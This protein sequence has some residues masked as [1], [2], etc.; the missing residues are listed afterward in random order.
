MDYCFFS[1]LNLPVMTSSLNEFKVKLINR[2]LFAS[3]QVEVQR[4]S[5]AA[6]KTLTQNKLDDD[7]IVRFVDKMLLELDL[8]NPM[9]KNAQQWSNISMAKIIFY[10][11]KNTHYEL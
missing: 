8:F 6:I 11:F 10:R 7:I 9:N 2:I 5:D 3:S 4:F 1:N